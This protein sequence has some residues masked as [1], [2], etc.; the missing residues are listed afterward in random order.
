M[1]IVIATGIF[2]P[3]LGGP[4]TYAAK[5]A[6]EF[7][8]LGHQVKI[9]TYSD[10]SEYDFDKGLAYSVF[11][12]KRSN[13]VANYLNYFKT[14][15]KV[16][17]DADI[18]YA[19]DL[20]SVGLPC[21][22]LKLFKPKFKTKTIV[23]L[24]GD[25]L[26]EKAYNNNWNKHILS[27]YHD[28]P[29]KC[30]EKIYL[31]IYRFS[32]SKFDKIIFSTK[33]QKDIYA[34]HFSMTKDKSV[35]IFNAFPENS[36]AS[37]GSRTDNGCILFAGRL[38]K[39]KNLARVI[40][41]I[42]DLDNV[43]MTIIGDGPEKDNLLELVKKLGIAD[44]IYFKKRMLSRELAKE[45][46]NS[47]FTII[48]SVSEVSPNLALES[49]KLNKPVL[50]TKE[51]GFYLEFKDKL[52]FIDPLNI[53]DIQNKILDM[54]DENKYKKYLD[55]IRSIDSSRSWRDL[56]IEHINLFKEILQ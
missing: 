37:E 19:Q 31:A 13:K 10:K 27:H 42:K 43:E 9:I 39:L 7:L 6:E 52:I 1:K 18:I 25:F 44:R 4:A 50:L 36:H 30:K 3:E 17:K 12:I 40:T 53:K 34:K 8:K 38:I 5:I 49:I 16:A 26:W 28:Q 47:H 22:L 46:S 15:K 54:F 14:L 29:K 11:R 56:S 45:I 23:R 2:I 41:A 51:S 33:W 48:P 20:I 32:L 21:T 24:G 55:N 35:V